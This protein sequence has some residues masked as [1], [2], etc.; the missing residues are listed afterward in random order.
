M[1]RSPH[2]F[3]HTFSYINFNGSKD[4]FP[5]TI[6]REERGDLSGGGKGGGGGFLRS[7]LDSGWVGVL[8]D[9]LLYHRVD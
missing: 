7:R 8:S 1:P 4:F 6:L 3:D 2:I 5:P 9:P